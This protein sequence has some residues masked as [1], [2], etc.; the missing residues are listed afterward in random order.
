M[1]KHNSVAVKTMLVLHWE[2]CGVVGI[3]CGTSMIHSGS[4]TSVNILVIEIEATVTKIYKYLYSQSLW[5]LRF[6]GIAGVEY[7]NALPHSCM[8]LLSLLPSS[9]RFT[10]LYIQQWYWILSWVVKILVAFCSKSVGNL[11]SNSRNGTP[12]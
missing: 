10:N 4:Q 8:C 12:N 11:I 2:P 5:T 7:R 3:G 6:G 9:V 1:L